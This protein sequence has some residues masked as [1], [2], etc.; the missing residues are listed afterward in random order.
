MPE[1]NLNDVARWRSLALTLA[2]Q[3]SDPASKLTMSTSP[4]GMSISRSGPRDA[5]TPIWLERSA[6][7][8]MMARMG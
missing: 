8:W 3:M 1:D 2:A 4:W 6:A 5:R 7:P